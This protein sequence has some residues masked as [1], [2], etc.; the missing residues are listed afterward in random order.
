MHKKRGSLRP[1]HYNRLFYFN[2]PTDG[3]T[4]A[5][6]VDSADARSRGKL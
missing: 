6:S 1:S 5:T 3:A 4:S 2:Q